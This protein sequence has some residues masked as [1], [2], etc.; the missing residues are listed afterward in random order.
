MPLDSG[1]AKLLGFASLN[2]GAHGRVASCPSTAT[3]R[4]KPMK[5][6]NIGHGINAP[7]NMS[8]D[9]NC[10]AQQLDTGQVLGG[11]HTATAAKFD[12]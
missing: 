12:G 2:M 3:Q 1:I 10:G 6:S 8:I 11:D 4:S 9:I 7:P 5:R